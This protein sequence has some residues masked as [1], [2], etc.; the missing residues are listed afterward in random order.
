MRVEGPG[1]ELDGEWHD[2]GEAANTV[3]EWVVGIGDRVEIGGDAYGVVDE[4]FGF[5]KVVMF[6]MNGKWQGWTKGQSV[7]ECGLD[8]YWQGQVVGKCCWIKRRAALEGI[9]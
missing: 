2:Q 3:V 4:V 9:D 5:P 1:E 8:W 6:N 7:G